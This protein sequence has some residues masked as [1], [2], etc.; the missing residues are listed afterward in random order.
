MPQSD[1]IVTA[2][3]SPLRPVMLAAATTILG[4]APRLWDVFFAS[5]AVTIMA[6]LGFATVLTLIG[7]PAL[8]HSY[9]RAERRAGKP[10]DDSRYPARIAGY[11]L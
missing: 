1:A 5:M 6:G 8:Y 2:S 11:P 3:V 7:I 10:G 9:L 4:M